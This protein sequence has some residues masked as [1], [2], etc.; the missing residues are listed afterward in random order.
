MPNTQARIGESDQ[1]TYKPLR[2]NTAEPFFASKLNYIYH[3]II[4]L[5]QGKSRFRGKSSG[6]A[7]KGPSP[8][9]PL[10]AI[11]K[12][13]PNARATGT[14]TAF[15]TWTYLNIVKIRLKLQANDNHENPTNILHK[16]SIRTSIVISDINANRF[17]V[18]TNVIKN[19]KHHDQVS[20]F[21]M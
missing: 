4:I 12:E 19:V 3:S 7:S 5:G 17:L 20:R 18:K 11:A 1:S 15:P 16:N 8:D 13:Y 14:A 9:N 2:C 21:T 10:I 6:S